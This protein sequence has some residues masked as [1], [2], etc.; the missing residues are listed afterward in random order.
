MQF[1]SFNDFIAMGGYAFYVWLSFGVSTA[2]ILTL[3]LSSIFGHKQVIKNIALRVQR[4]DRLR[5][6]R[7]QNKKNNNSTLANIA[8]NASNITADLSDNSPSN[9]LTSKSPNTSPKKEV[10]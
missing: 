10:Q 2:L 7:K 5:K 9:T 4:E 8:S 1:E 6:V 3:I